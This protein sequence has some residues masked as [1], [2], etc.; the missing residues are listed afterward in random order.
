MRYGGEEPDADISS[1]ERVLCAGEVLNAPA[2]EWLQK[3][4]L[5]RPRFR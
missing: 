4:V 2:W 3:T 5:R 1:L